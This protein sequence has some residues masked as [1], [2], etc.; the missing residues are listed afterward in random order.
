MVND[1]PGFLF[2]GVGVGGWGGGGVGECKGGNPN[3]GHDYVVIHM[4]MHKGRGR[5]CIRQASQ[6]E[7]ISDTS[8]ITTYYFSRKIPVCHI[9]N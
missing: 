5:H 9:L 4:Y 8:P 3:M 7:E 2:L 6:F 1:M